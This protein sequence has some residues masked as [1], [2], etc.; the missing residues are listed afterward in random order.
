[1]SKSAQNLQNPVLVSA[2]CPVD[3]FSAYAS[4]A[5]SS[6]GAACMKSSTI[7][8]SASSTAAADT[9][10]PRTC[11][12]ERESGANTTSQKSSWLLWIVLAPMVRTANCWTARPK[13]SKS[14]WCLLD[15]GAPPRELSVVAC[16]KIRSA[17]TCCNGASWKTFRGSVA[18]ASILS[19]L[20]GA[21]LRLWDRVRDGDTDMG[22]D[23][24]GPLE[25]TTTGFGVCPV[26]GRSM[27]KDTGPA[28]SALSK[29]QSRRNRL[30]FKV[31]R[32]AMFKGSPRD[33]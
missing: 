10:W 27:R 30:N 26:C 20:S 33:A 5:N 17:S 16:T 6:P 12:K 22:T 1:M 4:N 14:M 8:G 19:W 2:F 25:F 24:L 31:E 7:S 29:P 3:P 21:V 13:Q 15:L 11:S 18:L 9:S 32:Y 28:A 23:A